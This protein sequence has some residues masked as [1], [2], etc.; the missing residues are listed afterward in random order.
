MTSDETVFLRRGHWGK[1]YHTRDDCPY[2]PTDPDAVREVDLSTVDS[3]YSECQVCAGTAPTPR[4]QPEL[5]KARKL[6]ERA[7]PDDVPP[8]GTNGD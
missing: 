7:D 8:G 5:S 2:L 3:H 4:E 6:L 1:R